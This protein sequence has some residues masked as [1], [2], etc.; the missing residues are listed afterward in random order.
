VVVE[1]VTDFEPAA[2]GVTLPIAWS[3]VK[4]VACVVVHESVEECPVCMAVGL[5][6][7][8]QVGAGIIGGVTVTVAAQ[9]TVPPVPVAVPV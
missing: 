9:C 6:T 5:A 8:V 1:G 3:I 7:S 2:T 4:E